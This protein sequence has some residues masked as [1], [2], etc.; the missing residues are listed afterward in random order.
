MVV[1]E[2]GLRN[3]RSVGRRTAAFLSAAHA[4]SLF[5]GILLS[6]EAASLFLLAFELALLLLL[7]CRTV[8]FG[9]LCLRF[10]LAARLFVRSR[11]RGIR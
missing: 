7:R 2:P 11:L 8:T 1:L 3:W 4:L 10:L 6:F 5:S 9:S